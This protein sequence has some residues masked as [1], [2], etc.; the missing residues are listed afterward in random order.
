MK[1]VL[2]ES[3]AALNSIST[4]NHVLSQEVSPE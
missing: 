4:M 1:F 2:E 3:H